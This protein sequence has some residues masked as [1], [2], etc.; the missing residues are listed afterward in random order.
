MPD[1]FQSSRRKIARAKEHIADLERE[2]ERFVQE[3]SYERF[4]EPDPKNPT[5]TVHKIRMTKPLPVGLSEMAGDAIGNLREALDHA[6]FGVAVASGCANPRSAYFPFAGTIDKLDNAIKGWCKDVPQEIYPL[7]RAFKP[8]GGG[9]KVLFTLN[10]IANRNKHAL[11]IPVGAV[12]LDAGL[13]VRGT[14]FFSMPQPHVWDHA[15][16][17]MELITLGPG[18]QF[19]AHFRFAHTVAFAGIEVLEREPAVAVLYTI[20]SEVESVLA[21]IEAESRRLGFIIGFIN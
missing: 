4:T 18:A 3:A 7:L 14:G 5:H 1:P 10:Q 6:I 20:R 2:T 13:N 19:K 9:N 12:S 17:E 15:K 8:Y 16:N 11:L 21:A